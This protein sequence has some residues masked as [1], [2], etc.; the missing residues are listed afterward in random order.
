M[1]PEW[2][3][4]DEEYS[5]GQSKLL[6]YT[7][8]HTQPW[9]PF[10]ERFTYFRNPVGSV[11]YD[12]ERAADQA[13]YQIYD[14][15][16]PS[17]RY[18]DVATRLADAG[19]H[20]VSAHDDV[21]DLMAASDAKSVLEFGIGITG[22]VF[23]FGAN[24]TVHRHDPAHA[25]SNPS[26]AR[27]HGVVCRSGLSLLPDADVS[28]IMAVLFARAEHFVQATITDLPGQVTLGD[29]SRLKTWRREPSWWF[30]LMEACA[31][32]YPDLS[33]RVE[34][35]TRRHGA[36]TR[37]GGRNH[38]TPKV[39][40]LTDGKPG[41]TTQSIGLAEAL[42]WP[43][44]IKALNFTAL[45]GL[46]TVLR[47][48]L[49]A[50][51]LGVDRATSAELAAPWPDV[52]IATGWRPAPVTRWIGEQSRGR[53]RTV[54]LGRKGGRVAD[55]YDIVVACG[56]FQLPLHPRRIETSAPLN[57]VTT[58]SLDAAAAAWPDLYDQMVNPR[59]AL[60]FGGSSRRHDI[61]PEL[62][63]RIGAEV[64]AFAEASGGSIFAVTSRRSGKAATDALAEGF[65][66][67]LGETARIDRWRDNRPD[68][69]YLACLALAD[70]IVVTGESE[71][72]V[73]EAAACGKPV[74]IYPIPEKPLGFWT[75]I[76]SFIV[77]IALTRRHNRRGTLKPQR[78]LR[79]FC[80]RLIDRGL[81]QPRRNLNLLHE[82][83]VAR[84]MAQMFG[85]P[86][87]TGERPVLHEAD[88]VAAQIRQR[89]NLT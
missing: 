71:S 73:A 31:A 9:R 1:P 2:N 39:W 50:T 83:L 33:W 47:S 41:H 17:A 78:G 19:G 53:T 85:A 51:R 16:R 43:Y 54:Q 22:P 14:L 77:G 24:I 49:G 69:P 57:R 70:V 62:A 58:A 5:A 74:Y 29:G 32:R 61:A 38:R 88:E 35:H 63:R 44:E 68:N 79:R 46:G 15:D 7:G 66:D 34:I 67:A 36:Y 60:L 18:T 37:Q 56:Y 6:H 3:A 20:P 13:H 25:D 84:G 11:W 72:M 23:D 55:V 42:G 48:R 64:R 89:L 40:V 12:L 26:P 65:G 27:Y 81:V 4:R 30:A 86:L 10:P 80:A 87:E 8:L 21:N 52:A 82:A 59:I 28:W 75:R 76:E 45:A